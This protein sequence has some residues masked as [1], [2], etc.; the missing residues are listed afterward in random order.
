MQRQ[1]LILAGGGGHTG[2]AE[3]LAQE[4]Q[5]KADLSF[6]APDDE[7][8]SVERLT[9]YGAVDTLTKPRHPTTPFLSFLVRF[10][11]AFIQSLSKIKSSYDTVVCTGSNFC[12]PPALVAWMTGIP[13][14]VL[15]SRVK[16]KKP[17]RTVWI[18]RYFAKIVALQWEEQLEFIDGTVF[19]P[20]LPKRKVDPWNEGYVLVSGGT[21]G[22]EQLFDAVS[23]TNIKNVVLQTGKVDG[24]IYQNTHPDWKVITYTNKFHEL[25]AGAEVVVSPP[26]G[27]PVEAVTYGKPCVVAVYPGWAKA[28]D[29]EE[30]R[31]F[32]EKVNAV[33]LTQITPDSISKAIE[34]ARTRKVPVFTNGAKAL[35]DEI[36]SL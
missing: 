19:G 3:I 31:M 33:F 35:V 23:E 25:I 11:K 8:I 27:T 16:F 24:E 1:V 29:K 12:I 26:G 21:Y 36:L 22:Y 34:E 13:V 32:A 20:V 18:L 2:Y 28:A 5:G 4:F 15:E 17:S 6:L 30:T 9:P 10:L 7:P 14:V